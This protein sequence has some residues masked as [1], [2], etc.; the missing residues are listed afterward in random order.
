[1]KKR[2]PPID[3][4]N[5][6]KTLTAITGG[7][8]LTRYLRGSSGKSGMSQAEKVKLK[9]FVP[10]ELFSKNDF[11]SDFV[12][13]AACAS[14]QVEG[15]KNGIKGEDIWDRFSHTRGKIK[16]GENG[17]LATDFYHRY[18]EDIALLKSLNMRHFRFSIAWSRIFP[19][20]TGN[21]NPEGVAYYHKIID[22][23]IENGITPWITLYH[24]DL[25]QAL[26][27]RGGW[28]NRDIIE[29]FSNYVDRVTRE[30]G[31]KVKNW[32]V[33][34]EPQAFV[35]FGYALGIHA[36]GHKSIRNFMPAAHHA[37]LCQSEGG[38]IV[39]NNVTGANI[40]TTFS[41]SHVDPIN[42]APKHIKAAERLNAV[43]NRFFI[44]PALGM[45]YPADV[46][47]ALSRMKEYYQP[48]DEEKLKF[49]FDFIGIQNYFRVVARHSIFPPLLWAREVSTKK[50]HVP[51]NDMGMEISPEGMYK[52]LKQ[53]GQY[54][55]IKKI[56]VTENGVCFSD[57][58]DQ[59]QVHDEK[60]I[61]FFQDYL[62]AVL[63]AK[64]EGVKVEGYFVWSLTD[65][66]EWAEGFR[67]RFGLI[68][69]DYQTM[70]RTIKDSGFWFRDFLK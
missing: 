12:W 1:M 6:I 44:E 26:E 69:I 41:A 20:G 38:R 11:G 28:L 53:M 66:F 22:C 40:G 70:K 68:Y 59:G 63:R 33:L 54:P 51:V 58:L 48:G 35:G 57:K 2:I 15:S 3:R 61:R 24:W 8:I 52:I 60:R 16:T 50:L 14:Y 42:K 65:N 19:E 64:K 25:P 21:I 17:D 4:R 32:I 34:N 36:P 47:P 45:G 67:P 13:G 7:L 9:N 39:R 62:N 18:E 23:C 31:H 56:I 43:L 10:Q 55:N 49:D 30:Y 46:I 27:D 29:W 37:A 5:V